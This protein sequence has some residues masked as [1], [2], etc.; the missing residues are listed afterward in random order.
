MVTVPFTAPCA[1]KR[2]FV[3]NTASAPGADGYDALY[4]ALLEQAYV[5]SSNKT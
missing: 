3:S 5:G 1:A 2:V 4:A